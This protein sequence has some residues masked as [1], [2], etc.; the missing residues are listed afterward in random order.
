VRVTDRI[1]DSYFAERRG[2]AKGYMRG[3][4]DATVLFI[5]AAV[6]YAILT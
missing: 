5:L 4:R 6:L 2:E 1:I 3:L